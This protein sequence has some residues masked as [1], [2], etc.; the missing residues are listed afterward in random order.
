MNSLYCLLYNPDCPVK[1]FFV[2]LSLLLAAGSKYL[3]VNPKKSAPSF[4]TKLG[5]SDV[6]NCLEKICNCSKAIGLF[7]SVL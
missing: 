5:G 4:L 3:F 6:Y 1:T 7:L 2:I